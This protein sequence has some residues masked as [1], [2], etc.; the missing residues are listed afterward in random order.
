MVTAYLRGHK[1]YYDGQSWKYRDTGEPVNRAGQEDRPC[2][3]CGRPPTPEGYDAC[4]GE[5]KGA[6]AAC[7]GHGVEEGY[8]KFEG[9]ERHD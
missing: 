5:I 4:L 7:C 2:A 1:A 9:E 8:I 6:V 3:R